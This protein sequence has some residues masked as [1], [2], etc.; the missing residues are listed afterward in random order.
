MATVLLAV[1]LADAKAWAEAQPAGPVVLVPVTPRSPHACRGVTA[2]A[3][4][5]TPGAL[6]LAPEVLEA[7]VA[8]AMVC[9][10]WR[11]S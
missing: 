2:D 9:V 8:E 10:A 6:L 5:A 4:L 1:S 7:L 3:V 11:R